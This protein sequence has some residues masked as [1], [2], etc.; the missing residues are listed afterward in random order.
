M[1]QNKYIPTSYD[2]FLKDYP[3]LKSE[4]L[5]ENV[6]AD[7]IDF[8][9]F[10]LNFLKTNIDLISSFTYEK[11]KNF[12]VHN[13]MKYL[14]AVVANYHSITT[15]LNKPQSN[16]NLQ[17]KNLITAVF[18]G[19]DERYQLFRYLCENFHD[20]DT[21]FTDL[22]KF[23]QIYRFLNEGQEYNINMN[24]YKELVYIDYG[25]NYGDRDIRAEVQKHM[26]TLQKLQA[27]RKN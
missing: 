25:F 10:Y 18:G 9:E 6:D 3:I 2:Q 21:R 14:D 22:T 15:T 26:L 11:I 20:A 12:L 8:D 17:K 16:N 23:N 19:D 7:D 24:A 1:D 4:W 13:R 27:N 5:E